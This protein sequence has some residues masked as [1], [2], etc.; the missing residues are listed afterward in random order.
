MKKHKKV[1]TVLN[2]IEHLFILASAVT[3]FVLTS[4]FASSYGIPIDIAS[5]EVGLKF[6][7]ITA[8]IK[9]YKSIIKKIRKAHDKLVFLEKLSL[10]AFKL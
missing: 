7:T 8:E 6:C 10:I 2:Y 1:C 3:G 9:Q 4:A 5:P